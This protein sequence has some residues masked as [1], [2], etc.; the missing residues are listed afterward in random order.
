MCSSDQGETVQRE[1]EV[2]ELKQITSLEVGVCKPAGCLPLKGLKGSRREA[3][4]AGG[5][6]SVTVHELLLALCWQACSRSLLSSPGV[7]LMKGTWRVGP[8]RKTVCL[9]S[10][11]ALTQNCRA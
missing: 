11:A 9:L 8:G 2:R 4:N 7:S 5:P 3:S 6:A 10:A 1:E